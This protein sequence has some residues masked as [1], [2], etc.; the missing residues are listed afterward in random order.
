MKHLEGLHR[1]K[2][3]ELVFGGYSDVEDESY[4]HTAAREVEEETGHFYDRS[5]ILQTLQNDKEGV[6]VVLNKLYLDN[7]AW[8][9]TILTPVQERVDG[10]IM[11]KQV[12]H[13]FTRDPRAIIANPSLYWREC[14]GFEWRLVFKPGPSEKFDPILKD[15][16]IHLQKQ[17]LFESEIYPFLRK[18]LEVV[19]QKLMSNE[20]K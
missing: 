6:R 17:G 16:D 18:R 8:Y 20:K 10:N 1:G 9:A 3:F 15:A 19:K 11:M 2:S 12:E 5:T 13:R 4:L 14:S 7:T